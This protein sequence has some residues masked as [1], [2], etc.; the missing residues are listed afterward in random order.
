M[1]GQPLPVGRVLAT[2]SKSRPPV[3]GGS[4]TRSRSVTAVVVPPPKRAAPVVVPPP[5]RAG[6]VVAPPTEPKDAASTAPVPPPQAV[7]VPPVA[8][9]VPAVPARVSPAPVTPPKAVQVPPVARAVPALPAR[10]SPAPVTPPKAV[11]VPHVSRLL[12]AEPDH[13][14][15]R[16]T[17]IYTCGENTDIGD[18]GPCVI[19]DLRRFHDP[20]TRNDLNLR[21]HIGWHPT[22]MVQL[23]MNASFG[24]II[25]RALTLGL[26]EHECDFVFK[27]MAGRHRSV[28]AATCC[29][30]ILKIMLGN[31][32][33]QERHLARRGWSRSTCS[34][35]CRECCADLPAYVNITLRN[36]QN[37]LPYM[38]E[39]PEVS[40]LRK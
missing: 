28:C 32:N 7:Q 6:V 25:G 15:L 22:M 27:C 26:R 9:A 40:L 24:Q 31:G 3:L 33:V 21:G 37:A 23:L 8:R 13:P 1:S 38:E 20:S 2:T 36:I 4:R 39:V 5:R 16:H 35:L 14:P 30:I 19:V 12:P 17:T 18:F 34:G 10:V 29:G 11:Q